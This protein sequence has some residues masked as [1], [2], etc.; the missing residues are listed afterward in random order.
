MKK[1][2]ALFSTSVL[3][4]VL[5]ALFV[6][7][8][9][10]ADSD[11][12]TV[13]PTLGE[14]EIA[15]YEM[16]SIYSTFPNYYDNAKVADTQWGGSSRMYP[17]NETRLRVAQFDESGTATGKYYAVYFAGLTQ[18]LDDNGDPQSGAGCNILFYDVKDG[19]VITAKSSRGIMATAGNAADPSLS[20]MRTNISGQ[21]IQFD[22][23]AIFTGD[24]GSSQYNRALWFNAQGQAI[25]GITGD[26][27]FL[28]SGADGAP[29]TTFA[30]EYCYSNGKVVKAGADVTCDKVMAEK[31]DEQ[32]NPVTDDQGNA[33]MEAT[34]EDHY[35][36]QRFMWAYFTAE[37]WA[38][39][40]IS[41]GV[42]EV[43]YLEAGWDSN[44][45]DYAWEQD[46]GYMA[47]AFLSG[48]GGSAKL[49]EEQAKV[50]TAN[51][52]GYRA[53][54]RNLYLPAGGYSY[55]FGYLDKGIAPHYANYNQ[56]WTSAYKYGR[57]TGFAA[58]KTYNFSVSGL[59]SK[60]VVRNNTSFQ[61]K[62]G[63]NVVEVMQGTSFKPA[64]NVVYTG[65]T[66]YW[67]ND[68]DVTSFTAQ[69]SACDFSLS[70]NGSNEVA[71]AKYAS[72]EEMVADFNKDYNAYA[73][74]ELG[75]AMDTTF[76]AATGNLTNL[77]WDF[78][79]TTATD[80]NF[81]GFYEGKWD[82]LSEYIYGYCISLKDD[83]S[84]SAY[85]GTSWAGQFASTKNCS[86]PYNYMLL[87]NAFFTGGRCF[88]PEGS[89]KKWVVPASQN[90][91]DFVNYTIDT[92]TAAIDDH[93]VCKMTVKGKSASS[94][95]TITYV[96]VDSYTPILKVNEDA[97]IVNPSVV[98]NKV[99][100]PAID[101]YSLVNAYNAKY[102]S[103][104]DGGGILGA[105]IT[106]EVVFTGVNEEF[107]AKPKEGNYTVTATI[108]RNGKT[109]SKAFTLKIA[110]ITK[111]NVYTRDLVLTYGADF[112]VTM[113]MVAAYDAVDGNLAVSGTQ[114]CIDVSNP[115]VNT[116]KPG[117][118][119]V[120]YEVYDSSSNCASGSY[121]VTVLDKVVA[122]TTALTKKLEALSDSVL[123]LQDQ[124]DELSDSVTSVD[125]ATRAA[126]TAKIAELKTQMEALNK[127]VT[128]TD[129]ASTAAAKAEMDE[130]K[131]KLA[132]LKEQLT[133]V[134]D[135]VASVYTNTKGC[136]SKDLYLLEFLSAAALVVL[137]LR[138]KQN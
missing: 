84:Y 6:A 66:R 47:I 114:W 76:D 121:K 2:F 52:T 65:L 104:I 108:T 120:K 106:S 98:D 13:D 87:L 116:Q 5:V 130:L 124:V 54:A 132:E 17:W 20:H 118:Y 9:V 74:D 105:D 109:V 22:A 11:K 127:Q 100:V 58:Q 110:D 93:Y 33:V 32:G 42:N 37:E 61:L 55:D 97:L 92:S 4:I 68:D 36:Y 39:T 62:E 18:A 45:W 80:S 86:S 27:Y 88:T 89:N 64:D 128:D 99:V 50:D 38:D 57:T 51:T 26:P 41:Y 29:T 126:I 135:K 91:T 53:C 123:D 81:Y 46:G 95:L 122:D 49:T 56:M 115:K 71:K 113:G 134:G 90:E 43:S 70:V 19:Q 8:T 94:T 10:E 75:T 44:K 34:N 24:E 131:A 112:D 117:K 48:E 102:T 21:A 67:G 25:R 59:K 79:G 63:T 28:K 73:H 77:S 137:L 103:A 1:V 30:P 129:A 107:W 111:P 85:A 125:E 138:K 60:D 23:T 40:K 3:A 78:I 69:A 82:W 136:N 72:W 133:T 83:A 12:W 35:L 119:T 16:N 14:D 7:P 101:K 96:V 15:M 31:L